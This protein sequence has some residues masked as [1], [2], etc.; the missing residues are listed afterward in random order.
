MTAPPDP[1]VLLVAAL[2]AKTSVSSL[3]GNRIATRLSGTYPAVRITLVG[4]PD[5]PT[6][7]T[8]QPTLQWEAWGNGNDSAAEGQ[9]A[10]L[11]QAIDEV[12]AVLAGAYAAGRITSSWAVGHYF[13]SA[14]A[15]TGRERFIGQIG[16]LTQP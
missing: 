8:A 3:C 15:T 16:M 6:T 13:H 14:D 4:G 7:N 1:E 5:R 12:A 11:A 10:D 9:A 2:K